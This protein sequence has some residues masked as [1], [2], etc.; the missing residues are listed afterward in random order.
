MQC[1]YWEQA[2][3]AQDLHVL[4]TYMYAQDLHVFYT[5]MYYMYKP[6]SSY[7]TLNLKILVMCVYASTSWYMEMNTD[8]RLF[9]TFYLFYF[10]RQGLT[11]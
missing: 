3:Y 5:Y 11:I 4:Y 9:I 1:I 2:K 6:V 8:V 7:V 10:L